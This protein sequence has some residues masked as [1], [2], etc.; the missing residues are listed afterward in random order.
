MFKNTRE[1]KASS[2]KSPSMCRLGK[3]VLELTKID[4]FFFIDFGVENASAT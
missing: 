1:W 4:V 2:M 3:K